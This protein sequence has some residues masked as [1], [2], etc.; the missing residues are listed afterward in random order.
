MKLTSKHLLLSLSTLLAVG[1]SVPLDNACQGEDLSVSEAQSY[2]FQEASSIAFPMESHLTKREE[3]E[4]PKNLTPNEKAQEKFKKSLIIAGVINGYLLFIF[5]YGAALLTS[6]RR[7][8]TER[9]ALQPILDQ[10]RDIVDLDG[11]V[12]INAENLKK[13]KS[14][15]RKI[16]CLRFFILVPSLPVVILFA[17][18]SIPS[19]IFFKDGGLIEDLVDEELNEMGVPIQKNLAQDFVITRQ[20]VDSYVPQFNQSDVEKFDYMQPNNSFNKV[21]TVREVKGLTEKASDSGNF[22]E[23]IEN[24]SSCTICLLHYDDDEAKMI[25]FP[26]GHHLH[27]TC[28]RDYRVSSRKRFRDAPAECRAFKCFICQLSLLNQ[29]LYYKEQGYP[30]TTRF[31]NKT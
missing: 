23:K 21:L 14:L 9:K 13:M 27:Y 4:K 17:L 12:L 5:I 30:D 15:N 24:D 20:E 2:E 1:A 28:L 10:E 22:I 11:N 7:K 6:Y 16:L 26:C 8:V 18:V 19:F 31:V 29:Y 25:V 3:V